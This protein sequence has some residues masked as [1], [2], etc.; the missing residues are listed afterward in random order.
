MDNSHLQSSDAPS[1]SL[2]TDAPLLLQTGQ[3]DQTDQTDQIQ[4]QS[5]SQLQQTDAERQAIARFLASSLP[6]PL[7]SL[8]ESQQQALDAAQRQLQL[9]HAKTQRDAF[10]RARLEASL[11]DATAEL[12]ASRSLLVELKYDPFSS[13]S[14]NGSL[15]RKIGE[16]RA[17]ID[18]LGLDNNRLRNTADAAIQARIAADHSA[19]A[20]QDALAIIEAE[21]ISLSETL[22]TTQQAID[23]ARILNAELT[24]ENAAQ[25]RRISALENKLASASLRL[26]KDGI[27][28]AVSAR[29]PRHCEACGF[30]S[31]DASQQQVELTVQLAQ[32]T[33]KLAEMENSFK[34]LDASHSAAL[35]QLE[36][37]RDLLKTTTA[38]KSDL[39]TQVASLQYLHT[40]L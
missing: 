15:Q 38:A 19:R 20:A 29:V 5:Q 32:V 13:L 18:L 11:A 4:S 8:L 9:L 33:S 16:M 27:D 30:D 25:R 24:A 12:S 35:K 2:H 7:R 17:T 28:S 1:G 31:A 14:V 40:W 39:E 10:E 26:S 6:N 36:T 21:K 37:E 23:E 22:V 34:L 3:T